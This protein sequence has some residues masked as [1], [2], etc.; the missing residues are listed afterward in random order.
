M[1][2][3]LLKKRQGGSQNQNFGIEQGQT[4]VITTGNFNFRTCCH[5]GIAEQSKIL[6]MN[7]CYPSKSRFSS[8]ATDYESKHEKM[9]RDILTEYLSDIHENTSVRDG[10]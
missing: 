7:I 8:E 9:T 10:G 1:K 4:G 3:K 6:I 2:S 5:T